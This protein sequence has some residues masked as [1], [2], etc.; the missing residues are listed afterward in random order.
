MS[1][2]DFEEGEP[3]IDPEEGETEFENEP[4]GETEFEDEEPEEEYADGEEPQY[5]EVPGGCG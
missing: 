4:E 3:D 2:F 5:D 1:R